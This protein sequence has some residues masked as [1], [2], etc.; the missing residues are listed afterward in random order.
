MPS[1]CPRSISR[2]RAGLCKYL[3]IRLSQSRCSEPSRPS[4]SELPPPRKPPEA[5][6]SPRISVASRRSDSVILGF[7]WS[8]PGESRLSAPEHRGTRLAGNPYP[9]AQHDRRARRCRTA[10]RD[11]IREWICIRNLYPKT[12]SEISRALRARLDTQSSRVRSSGLRDDAADVPEGSRSPDGNQA[13]ALVP[14]LRSHVA[15]QSVLW[16]LRPPYA[17]AQ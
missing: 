12:S 11:Q 14:D 17:H 7:V 3:Q 10:D 2:L 13:L 16:L 5:S 1:R 4:K 15:V 8:A 9:T 6:A